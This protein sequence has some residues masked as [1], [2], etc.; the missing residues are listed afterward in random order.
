LDE[1]AGWGSSSAAEQYALLAQLD[2]RCR[3]VQQ[4]GVICFGDI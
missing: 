1:I 4:D 3:S 2:L